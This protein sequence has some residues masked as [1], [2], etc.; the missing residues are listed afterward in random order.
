MAEKKFESLE[1]LD[2]YL[3]EKFEKEE[4]LEEEFLEEEEETEE[5]LVEEESE[6]EETVELTESA[7]ETE[8][9]TSSKSP[10][11][12]EFAFG[13]LRHENSEL[14]QKLEEQEKYAKKMREMA[15]NLG[16]SSADDL[17]TAYEEQQIQKEAHKKN[18]DPELYHK[19]VT[20]EKELETIKQ[21][22]IELNKKAGI[23]RFSLSLEK[24]GLN[25]GLNENEQ[26]QIVQQMEQDG[27]TLD[28]IASLKNPERFI[29]GYA[30]DQIAEKKYQEMLATEKK[31]KKLKEPKLRGETEPSTDW[32]QELQKELNQYAKENNL[33]RIK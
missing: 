8:E 20:M 6:E 5:E 13:K 19:M 10:V 26:I 14:K 15:T 25:L 4:E 27:Y 23:E 16:Y 30:A 3:D 18:I 31:A 33:Y 17:I 11:K 2:K 7:P 28:D 9:P 1:E 32:E 24:I 29:K 21:R 22:E 12:E